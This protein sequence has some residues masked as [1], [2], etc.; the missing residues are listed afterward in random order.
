[1]HIRCSAL[2]LGTKQKVAA[3]PSATLAIASSTTPTRPSSLASP[4][5]ASAPPC[6]PR[7][8]SGSASAS[9]S[10]PALSLH[11]TVSL[12]CCYPVSQ[13]N[14][15]NQEAW[16]VTPCP[17]STS[18][19]AMA[20]MKLGAWRLGLESTRCE[21]SSKARRVTPWPE[22]QGALA[23]TAQRHEGSKEARGA[24]RLGL[25]QSAAQRRQ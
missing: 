25:N 24:W 20:V 16:R 11:S 22:G 14:L 1:M 8:P 2:G 18:C 13:C 9:I 19:S 6:K 21:G 10:K 7:H 15:R 4:P 17:D 5:T 12:S 3:P 23:C